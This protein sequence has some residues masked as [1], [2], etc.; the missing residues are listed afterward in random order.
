MNIDECYENFC[1]HIRDFHKRTGETL[2][3]ISKKADIPMWEMIFIVYKSS[4]DS[5][6]LENFLK[7]CN[8]LNLSPNEILSLPDSI[9]RKTP[10]D[11]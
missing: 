6:T 7:L 2:D 1:N 10:A 5:I 3:E 4:Q 11:N 9:Q 8:Y